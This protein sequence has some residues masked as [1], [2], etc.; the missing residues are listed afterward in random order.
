MCDEK[1]TSGEAPPTRALDVHSLY[2]AMPCGL[3]SVR[4]PPPEQSAVILLTPPP[5]K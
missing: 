4:R 1:H 3:L 5:N 2:T